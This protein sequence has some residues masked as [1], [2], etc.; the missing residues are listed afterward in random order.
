M[1]LT[2]HVFIISI[3]VFMVLIVNVSLIAQEETKSE[4]PTKA[5][6][7]E[8]DD[9]FREKLG[10]GPEDYD[11]DFNLPDPFTTKTTIYFAIPAKEEI[12]LSIFDNDWNAV[13]TLVAGEIDK[14]YYQIEWN[15]TDD[16]GKTA[17]SG[18][19]YYRLK[20]GD[21]DQVAK[22]YFLLNE[23]NNPGYITQQVQ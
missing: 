8:N 12:T 23:Q 6:L 5:V 20:A 11:L 4:G 21:F 3:I 22:M 19:Y 18:L 15:G 1:N 9:Y 17:K 10:G 2:K 13:K 14:G 16:D 7:E